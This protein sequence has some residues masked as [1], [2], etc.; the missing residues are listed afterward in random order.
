MEAIPNRN[1]S[2]CCSMKKATGTFISSRYLGFSNPYEIA[3]LVQTSDEGLAVC[4]TTYLAGR[5]PRICIFKLSK[6]ELAAS[7]VNKGRYG[8]ASKG[9]ILSVQP[10]L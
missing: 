10:F 8:N 9:W 3:S 7:E 2:V 4:G 1:K 6:E 5:F